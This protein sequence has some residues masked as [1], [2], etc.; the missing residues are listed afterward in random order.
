MVKESVIEGEDVL[1]EAGEEFLRREDERQPEGVERPPNIQE[2]RLE[3]ERLRAEV[4][5]L[6]G[7][8]ADVQAELDT[9]IAAFNWYNDQLQEALEE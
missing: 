5:T 6:Q 8:F 3:L 4:V 7:R 1:S 2:T 9:R